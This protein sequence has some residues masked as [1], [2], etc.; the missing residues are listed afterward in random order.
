MTE[1]HEEDAVANR[2]TSFR[3]VEDTLKGYQG[4]VKVLIAYAQSEPDLRGAVDEDGRLDPAA[5]T[6]SQLQ[7]IFGW[8]VTN[9][10]CN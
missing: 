3:H 4:K 8:L 5:I 1:D 10:E 7:K 6:G 2:I 9:P